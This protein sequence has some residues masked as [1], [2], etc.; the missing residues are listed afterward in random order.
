MIQHNFLSVCHPLFSFSFIRVFMFSLYYSLVD[1]A[2]PVPAPVK[3][4][5][6]VLSILDT[7]RYEDKTFD[8]FTTLVLD[9]DD[10]KC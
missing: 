2:I 10:Q 8:F 3:V 5:I 7:T 6:Q 9:A 1:Q 4:S